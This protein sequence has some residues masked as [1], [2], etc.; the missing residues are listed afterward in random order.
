[1]KTTSSILYIDDEP[2]NL[3]N[4]YFIFR[5][6]YKV[7]IAASTDKAKEILKKE[8]IEVIITDQRM[9]NLTGVEFLKQ[10]KPDYPD[11]VC[12]ILTGYSDMEA[13]TVAINEI[14]IFQYITKPWE[15]DQ[16]KLKIDNALENY[17]LRKKNRELIRS[18][19]NSNHKLIAKINDLDTFVYRASHDINGP[20]ARMVGLCNVALEQFKSSA[21]KTYFRNIKSEA[22][23]MSNVL[24]NLMELNEIERREAEIDKIDFRMMVDHLSKRLKETWT[25][26]R[27]KIN[28]NIDDIDDFQSDARLIKAI[29]W[30][31]LCNAVIYSNPNSEINLDIHYKQDKLSIEVNDHGVG[32]S[33]EIVDRVFDKFFRGS[34]YSRGNGLGLH[35]VKLAV[36]RLRGDIII[37][38][39]LNEGTR[40]NVQIPAFGS[41]A[42]SLLG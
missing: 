34:T 41:D 28:I 3:D 25:N 21:N 7:F 30:Q 27:H 4:F 23:L 14:G 39:H 6:D 32:I 16:L 5:R 11:I 12:M 2:G 40:V 18:L 20:L 42:N 37:S 35:L 13:I 36:E 10:I 33:D 1:M 38:S 31:L 17:R 29:I 8:E 26:S 15:K 9:P 22:V 19:R 24:I